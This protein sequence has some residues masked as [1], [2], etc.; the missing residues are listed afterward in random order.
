MASEEVD[1]TFEEIRAISTTGELRS[2][3]RIIS[4]SILLPGKERYEFK[5]RQESN[6]VH[7]SRALS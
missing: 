3:V 4:T 1:L 7:S 6:V 5:R 2:L